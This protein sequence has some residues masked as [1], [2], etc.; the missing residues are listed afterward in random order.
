[1]L[2]ECAVDHIHVFDSRSTAFKDD[3]VLQEN[4]I[5][6]LTRGK[7]QGDVT[8]S[9]SSGE[10]LEVC[11]RRVA[12]FPEIVK[13]ADP[14]YFIHI[15]TS[16]LDDTDVFNTTLSTLGL[17]VRTGPVVDFRL[18]PWLV[19]QP[20]ENTVPLIYPHHHGGDGFAYPRVHKKANALQRCPEVEKWLMPNEH[21]VLVKRFSAKEERRRVVAY[22]HVPSSLNSDLVGFENHWNVFHV[23][24]RGMDEVLA[25]GLACFLNSTL[26]DSHFRMFSGHTQ[27]NATD[28]RN[29][30]YPTLAQLLALGRH[31][32]SG[33]SQAETDALLDAAST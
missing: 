23:G 27:V 15:P 3:G 10:G 14:E 28:L 33:L 32:R 26:L 2:R 30:K 19:A 21:Y 17:S 6:K 25:R 29:I 18:K 7:P 11:E 20:G 31:Y 16:A 22:V 5:L 13:G 8:I 9:R 4:I 1:M 12:M 24:K